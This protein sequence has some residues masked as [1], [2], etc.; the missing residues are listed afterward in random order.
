MKQSVGKCKKL[1]SRIFVYYFVCICLFLDQKRHSDSNLQL[2]N[3]RSKLHSKKKLF[4]QDFSRTTCSVHKRKITEESF[5][6]T[7]CT[8]EILLNLLFH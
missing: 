7:S 3:S 2:L 8:T 1:T 6:E 5:D 4:H